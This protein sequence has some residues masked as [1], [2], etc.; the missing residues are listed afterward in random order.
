M[1]KVLFEGM[2]TL[3]PVHSFLPSHIS[4]AGIDQLV[5]R[6]ALVSLLKLDVPK[7]SICLYMVFCLLL[8]HTL[9]IQKVGTASALKV[10]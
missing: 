7:T 9:R 10:P 6:A 3:V 4:K 5:F 8:K 2:K 1:H